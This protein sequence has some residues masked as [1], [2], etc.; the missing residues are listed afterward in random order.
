M[1]HNHDAQRKLAGGTDRVMTTLEPS[2]FGALAGEL[3]RD[4]SD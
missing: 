1:Q 2:L 4:T 3:C